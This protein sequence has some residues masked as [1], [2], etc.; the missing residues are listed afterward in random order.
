MHEFLRYVSVQCV[1]RGA[2]IA[3]VLTTILSILVSHVLLQDVKMSD[4]IPVNLR[5]K[6][7]LMDLEREHDI[8]QSDSYEMSRPLRELQEQMAKVQAHNEELEDTVDDKMRV[9]RG[10]GD[11]LEGLNAGVTRFLLHFFDYHSNR[12]LQSFLEKEKVPLQDMHQALDLEQS[13]INL[14]RDLAR[15]MRHVMSNLVS[16]AGYHREETRI[17][18]GASCC[19]LEHRP[20]TVLVRLQASVETT[21]G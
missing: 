15:L 18:P 6:K 21:I 17:P 5:Q 2:L 8:L 3:N 13:G 12:H 14:I 9:I 1:E 11:S 7:L 19:S 4:L 16:R 10:L 20:G